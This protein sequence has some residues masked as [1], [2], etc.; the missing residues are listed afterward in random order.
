M[1]LYNIT[2]ILLGLFI[3]YQLLA[4]ENSDNVDNVVTAD[5]TDEIKQYNKD[6]E[7]TDAVIKAD[8]SETDESGYDKRGY[9]KWKNMRWSQ[10]NGKR[11]LG[12]W[13]NRKWW[14][15]QSY[16]LQDRNGNG[17]GHNLN[18]R[19]SGDGAD[20]EPDKNAPGYGVLNGDFIIR[21]P[22][23]IMD[24]YG[25]GDDIEDVP[26]NYVDKRHSSRWNLV[27]RKLAQLNSKNKRE[28]NS[29]EEKRMASRWR[30][31]QNKLNQ[32]HDRNSKRFAG[33]WKNQNWLLQQA[34]QDRNSPDTN[35]EQKRF[36]GG[37]WWDS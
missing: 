1:A 33:R 16:G 15:M 19:Y 14:E 30:I 13:K 5:E 28:D 29:Q 2:W 24:Y 22:Y 31:I 37:H 32:L 17:F 11:N 18:K 10:N 21:G 36:P 27:H 35:N 23:G 6:I 7:R 26:D 3:Q 4:A 8:T 12:R 9:G 34:N 25:L 20:F